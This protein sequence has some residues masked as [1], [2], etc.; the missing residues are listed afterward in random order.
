MKKNGS[1]PK[2]T[3]DP[4]FEEEEEDKKRRR[5]AQ[6]IINLI[7]FQEAHKFQLNLLVSV[8]DITSKL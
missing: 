1:H 8:C 2:N 5:N 4:V 6:P 3:D 7:N